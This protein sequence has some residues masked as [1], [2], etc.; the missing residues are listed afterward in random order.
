MAPTE[1][2]TMLISKQLPFGPKDGVLL[3]RW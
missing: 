1:S 3:N 2:E